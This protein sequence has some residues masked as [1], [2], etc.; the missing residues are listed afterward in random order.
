MTD[1]TI[2]DATLKIL[3]NFSVISSSVLLR[4]GAT[5]RTVSPSKS[6]MAIAEFET[7]WPLETPSISCQNC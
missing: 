6:I 3:K 1:Y 7:P 5:Q 2:S 4:K